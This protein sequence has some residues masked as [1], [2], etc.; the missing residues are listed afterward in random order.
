MCRTFIG[1]YLKKLMS[2]TKEIFCMPMYMLNNDFT[3]KYEA[4]KYE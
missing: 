4:L 1:F 3:R 2:M